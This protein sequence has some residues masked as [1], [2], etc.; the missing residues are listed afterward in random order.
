MSFRTNAAVLTEMY[1]ILIA[2][3]YALAA[4][5]FY[6]L[7]WISL[8]GLGWSHV[9]WYEWLAILGWALCPVFAW[10]AW[11]ERDALRPLAILLISIPAIAMLA[12]TH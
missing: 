9:R 4:M 12:V 11:R 5:Y 3:V 8:G 10:F 7:G 1:L 6:T 2:A